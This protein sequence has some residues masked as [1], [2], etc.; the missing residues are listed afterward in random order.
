[1][2]VRELRLFRLQVPLRT[3]FEHSGSARRTTDNLVVRAELEDGTS[4][5]GEGVPRPDVTGEGAADSFEV[6]EG[7]GVPETAPA[8]GEDM[9]RAVEAVVGRIPDEAIPMPLG[10]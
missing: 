7:V 4:G 5:Y 10:P 2:R 3:K 8:S 6:L 9:F 1:M